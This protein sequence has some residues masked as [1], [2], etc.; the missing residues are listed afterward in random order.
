MENGCS[1]P[2]GGQIGTLEAFIIPVESQGGLT[3][4]LHG[5]ALVWLK[6]WAKKIFNIF[7]NSFQCKPYRAI[8]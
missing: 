1:F 2:G 8:I 6:N 5:H 7:N 3:S 4:T